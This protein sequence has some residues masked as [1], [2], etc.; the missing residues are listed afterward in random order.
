MHVPNA[1]SI[2]KECALNANRLR[3]RC[4]IRIKA[5]T[6]LLARSLS[7]LCLSLRWPRPTIA[8]RQVRRTERDWPAATGAVTRRPVRRRSAIQLHRQRRRVNSAATAP[9]D[10]SANPFRNPPATSPSQPRTL[11]YSAATHRL[12]P[13]EPIAASRDR[14]WGIAAAGQR[15]GRRTAGA[16]LKPSAMMRA[17]LSPPQ[18]FATTRPT[19]RFSDV[20]AGARSR[21]RANTAGRRV[22]GLC[23]SVADYY[24]GLREQDELRRLRPTCSE[25]ADVATGGGGVG[26]A[27]WHVAAGGRGV[28]ISRWRV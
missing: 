12:P 15:R 8:I 16:G 28:A 7:A 5:G 18:R 23:S 22:L 6:G 1:R 25:W 13:V 21:A 24:L 2:S 10:G 11:P 9:S 26:R 19:V 27:N 4:I 3:T 14:L 20:V 17:M